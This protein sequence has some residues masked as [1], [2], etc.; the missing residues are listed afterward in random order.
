MFQTFVESQWESC[1]LAE[2]PFVYY[3]NTIEED[4]SQSQEVSPS[5]HIE[6]AVLFSQTLSNLK[7]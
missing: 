4:S 7:G 3:L 6:E 5:T 2:L 1:S